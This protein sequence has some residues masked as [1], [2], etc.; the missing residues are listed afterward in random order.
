M[1]KWYD[2]AKQG[3][4]SHLMAYGRIRFEQHHLES[5]LQAIASVSTDLQMRM[6]MAQS[7]EEAVFYKA[8]HQRCEQLAQR[9]S[10]AKPGRIP[11]A[12][13][14]LKLIVSILSGERAQIFGAYISA[15]SN[16]DSVLAEKLRGGLVERDV[17][18]QTLQKPFINDHSQDHVPESDD[19]DE[20]AIGMGP[21]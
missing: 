4:D 12:E 20:D 1:A 15:R 5:S 14:E 6:G 13:E 9:L 18:I 11:L 10:T 16:G 17:F 7:Q 3:I 21:G 2:E 8:Q 19:E